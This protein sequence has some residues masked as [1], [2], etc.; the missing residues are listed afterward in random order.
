MK[1]L[2]VVG[3]V[4]LSLLIATSFLVAEATPKEKPFAGVK[5]RVAMID[6]E[7]E[8]A[9]RDLLPEFE[10]KT[11]IKV[12]I[13]T[14]GFEDLYNKILTASA[15]HTGEY[16]VCQFHF[17][18]MALFDKRGYMMDITEW[19]MRDADEIQLDDIH[20]SLQESHMKYNGRYCGVP[21]HV[22]S[23]TFYYRKDIFEDQGYEVPTNWEEVLEIAKDV[24]E[25]YGPDIRGF[26]FMGRADIQGAATYLNF[27]GGYGGDLYDQ[28]TFRP[29]VDSSEALQAMTMLKNLVAYSVKGSPSYGF[30]EAHVAFQQGRA[31][32]LPF[33]DSG[34]GFFSDPKQSDIIGKWAVAPMPGGR[35]TNGGWS[36]QISADSPNPEAA[37]EFLKW[38]ISP[39]MERRLVPLKPSCRISILTD[40]EF[41]KYPSYMGFYNVLE[42]NP[43]PFPKIT[44][45]WQMLQLL[46]KAE[47][48]VVTGQMTPAKSLGWLQ[49]Q[50]KVIL[51]RYD[52]WKPGKSK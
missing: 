40:S 38:I 17:P 13:D 8:W 46:G 29:T 51:L 50:Y 1:V 39:E 24:D 11:G 20:P 5:L 33:W 16:D 18:D 6:E 19:V 25:K 30:D 9:F 10:E 49:E 26:V 21:T 28:K 37:W 31:A 23:M 35:A 14:Y 3:C 4:S 43:F 27:L 7:R 32:M 41:S 48:Q 12:T 47:N 34:D 15:A 52:L 22:G 36:V 45:N 2:K 44:P 42:G